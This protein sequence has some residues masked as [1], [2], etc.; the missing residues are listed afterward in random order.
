M[1]VTLTIEIH[2]FGTWRHAATLRLEQPQMGIRGPAI[3]DYEDAYWF[4]VTDG[5][6]A[7]FD[8]RAVSVRCPVDLSPRRFPTWPA[9]LL[10]L[11]PQGSA[12]QRLAQRWNRDPNDPAIELDLLLHG[13]AAPV[14]NLRVAEA[15]SAERERIAGLPRIG[16]TDA[17]LRDQDD[18]FD[19]IA[20]RF[21][22]TAS[23]SS[24]VQGEWPKLLLTRAR[25]GLWYPDVQVEDDDAIDHL[26]VK[27]LRGDGD[28]WR[29]IL[30]AESGYLELARAVGLRVG[31][32]L[33]HTGRALLIPRFDR[34]READG[35]LVRIGQESLVSAIG[36]AEF[37][38]V[39]RH[40][41][42]LEML[43]AVASDPVGETIEY[44]LRDAFNRA[45]GN[46]DNHGR[47][48]ALMKRGDG[49]IGLTP[50]Y[51]VAPMR[52]APTVVQ[53][54][55]HWGGNLHPDDWGAVCR[56]AAGDRV[57]AAKI[58]R[59][60]ADRA[61]AFAELPR[62]ARQLDIPDAVVDRCV[63]R[64]SDVARALEALA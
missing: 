11:M 4:D 8:A 20:E 16:L 36:V 3:L 53:R 26:L 32:A 38:H 7:P 1:T 44:V 49:R 58:V 2:I 13:A 21:A 61:P 28:E 64:A 22:L 43:Q 59:A 19:E 27:M 52:L 17:Q 25:D 46:T 40:E 15:W 47:N 30:A 35:A 34:E 39:G 56:A 51:D 29:Q 45:T 50:L 12:R 23:G 33:V 37:G 18:L 14:G 55:T 54:S 57:P 63:A 5:Q 31:R 6:T 10:D 24:G 42:Y 9:F 60:L 48:T 41:T 62:L